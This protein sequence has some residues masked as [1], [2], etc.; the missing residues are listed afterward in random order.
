M[1]RSPIPQIVKGSNSQS[2]LI[3]H[4]TDRNPHLLIEAATVYTAVIV[5]H[6]PGPSVTGTALG[7]TPPVAEV[8]NGVERT[9]EVTVATRKGCK[10]I[11]ISAIAFI[12]PTTRG[13]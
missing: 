7:S 8:A 1:G 12:V 9:I 6:V 3:P 10:A 5:V 11:I 2:V 4:A 13:F